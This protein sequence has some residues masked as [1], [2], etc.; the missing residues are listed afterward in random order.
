VNHAESVVDFASAAHG[1]PRRE[2][3]L[4]V[5]GIREWLASLA[6]DGATSR[7]LGILE[8]D[9]GQGRRAIL[10]AVR[11]ACRGM[12]IRVLRGRASRTLAF[13]PGALLEIFSQCAEDVLA[14]QDD[15]LPP[16][17]A[18][19]VARF[20][21]TSAPSVEH[22]SAADGEPERSRTCD[23]L[24]R[25]LCFLG[26]KG[27]LLVMI[28][29]LDLADALT[30]D[31]MR[32]LARMLWLRRELR[33]QPRIL[34]VAT[35]PEGGEASEELSSFV[36]RMSDACAF[37]IRA[38]G[39]S[40]D[41]IRDLIRDA[42]GG[43]APLSFRE[44][45]FRMT[46]GN[47]RHARWLVGH[48]RDQRVAPA[49]NVVGAESMEQLV[50]KRFAAL[51]AEEQRLVL[52]L[53]ALDHP[54]PEPWLAA[55][56]AER[57]PA[58]EEEGPDVSRLLDSLL[59]RG[60]IELASPGGSGGGP[61]YALAD[62]SAAAVLLES[63]GER[64]RE[65]N[66]SSIHEKLA[67][68]IAEEPPWRRLTFAGFLSDRGPAALVAA[69]GPC[70]EYLEG[71]GCLREALDL[72]DTVL[73]KAPDLDSSSRCDWMSRRAA[74]LRA[75][76]M[77]A[78]ALP[79]HEALAA[80]ARSAGEAAAARQAI[81]WL[82]GRLGDREAEMKEYREGLQLLDATQAPAECF[83]LRLALARALHETGAADPAAAL[84]GECIEGS[85]VIP[86][87]TH[88]DQVSLHGL[89]HD[90]HSRRGNLAAAAAEEAV[91]LDLSRAAPA[92]G[93]LVHF[94]RSAAQARAARGE[95]ERAGELLDGAASL[96]RESGSRWLQGFVLLQLGLLH[97]ER[98][99]AVLARKHLHEARGIFLDL[100][101]AEEG[102]AVSC[103]TLCL[104]FEDARFSA[105]G[106]WAR[107]LA[108]EWIPGDSGM[109]AQR[110][111]AAEEDGGT[112]RERIREMETG[113]G[114]QGGPH[115]ARDFLL[116]GKLLEDEGRLDEARRAYQESLREEAAARAPQIRT[117]AVHSLGRLAAIRGEDDAALRLFD[118]A[119]QLEEGGGLTRE[120]LLES[121]LEVSGIFLQK[122]SIGRA[123]DYSLRALRL[124]L[125]GGG[126]DLAV[127]A[128][129]GL[130]DLLADGGVLGASLD[131]AQ[132]C[133]SLS[134]TAGL[135]RWELVALR[136]AGRAMT[137]GE[138][139]GGA[140]DAFA[141]A[142]DLATSL[143]LPLEV[144]RVKL[145]LGWE[146]YRRREF[147]EALQLAR[148]GLETARRLSLAHLIDDLLHLIG[149]V[150]SAATNPRKNFLRAL[151]VLEQA[152]QGA[153]ARSRPRLRWEILQ[154][155]ARIY[156]ER[157]K[158][159]P[160][161]EH[162][163][164]AR[165]IEASVFSQVPRELRSLIWRSR[166]D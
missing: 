75:L 66:L 13:P 42:L 84:L 10:G 15:S 95:T 89:A 28:D 48:L 3:R 150:E 156:R 60:W 73:E 23:A 77:H 50:Q 45:L 40:R 35:L 118:Q 46:G 133:A 111:P 83:R 47:V 72:A 22:E 39:Y 126:K 69:L 56:A 99:D 24:A 119:L 80:G 152:L 29:D 153:G 8:G 52:G 26:T 110:G 68:F 70:A 88:A 151:E 123:F 25:A 27:P 32:Q 1:V 78:E 114:R 141:R 49:S 34:V 44:R 116:F 100:G 105:A 37:R 143:D 142:L 6:R 134:R 117:Q 101:R 19:Q 87:L 161:A 158:P 124:A 58:G 132:A 4:V 160:A 18:G 21:G 163:A 67:P 112:R 147:P 94:L 33:S 85:K 43:D 162:D 82:R 7:F 129:L 138:P 122:G 108:A 128:L 51:S 113:L 130:S 11:E 2:L 55:L 5:D 144:C 91:L 93:K 14:A 79:A 92:A 65:K 96:A 159:E 155:M 136:H 157:G 61:S 76:G 57:D 12:G 90:I 20:L 127:R 97:R 149:V 148:E 139:G 107:A 31:V 115:S 17:V 166:A 121:Y 63:L 59:E 103:A 137:D 106:R 131:M 16:G 120:V 9:E 74:L 154:A 30:L 104:E 62:P 38:R 102:H 54:L 135:S 125:E 86:G 81:G 140:L 71:I 36:L 64:V 165:Q 145:D 98:R 164:R 41:D 146:R 109:A 53:A